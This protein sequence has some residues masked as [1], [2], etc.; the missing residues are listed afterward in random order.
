MGTIP[1][2][3]E[4]TTCRIDH[5][6]TPSQVHVSVFAKKAD[7]ERSTVEIR[8][9]AV[10]IFTEPSDDQGPT[11]NANCHVIF[12]SSSYHQNITTN[13]HHLDFRQVLLDLYLP[14]SK[15]FKRELQ[16]F[17]P[18]DPAASTYKFYGT[19]VMS[20]FYLT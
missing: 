19:K 9:D 13:T 5:Y 20:W 12:S 6:Q 10:S 2:T 4:F 3:E 8:S 7:T 11:T 1:Q 14:D 18:V 15:R 17:G 16:L